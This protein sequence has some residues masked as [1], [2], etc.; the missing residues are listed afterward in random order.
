MSTKINLDD[1]N[2]KICPI[3]VGQKNLAVIVHKIVLD[4][5]NSNKYL[6]HIQ[7]IGLDLK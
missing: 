1:I 7:L 3:E 6:I 4:L 5:K 2:Q